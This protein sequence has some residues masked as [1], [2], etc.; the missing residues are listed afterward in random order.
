MLKDSATHQQEVTDQLGYQVRRG[1][2]GDHPVARPDRP[3]RGR[4]LLAGVPEPELYEAALT[5]MMRLVFLFSAEERDLLLLGDPLYDEHYAVST[6]VAQLQ[7]TADQHGEEVL[8]RRH[9]AWVRLLST[10][11]AVYGGV[12]H[13]RM[14][15]L[16]YAGNLFDPDRFPFLEGRKPGTT[17]KDTPATPLPIN[18]RTVLHL[19]RS[20]Q[21]LE[22]ARRGPPPELPGAR[23]RADRPRLRGP[24]RPH[25]QASHRAGAGPDRSQGDGARG[26]PGGTGAARRRRVRP[27]CVEFLKEENGR[28]RRSHLGE[29]APGEARSRAIEAKHAAGRLRQRRGSVNRVR[30]FAGLVRNDTFDQPVVIRKGSV[31]RHGG[32]R[33]AIQRHALHAPQPDR[34]HRPVHAGAAGLRWPRRGEAEGGV[35]TSIGQGTARPQDLRHGVWLG[36]V[37][38]PGVPL[39]VGAARRSVGR[40]REAAAPRQ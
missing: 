29:G 23:H 8:E 24:A 33:P 2:R 13:E 4:Q 20:L 30:P 36:G 10:F 34:T 5:V 12:Q 22:T 25:G 40:R 3:G 17:W 27:N 28:S 35:E 18:N 31:Y 16:P 6:L 19:L 26:C 37:S 14:K 9:D 38:G 32:H 21:Y 1:R 39:P 7:E 11:R 15:L